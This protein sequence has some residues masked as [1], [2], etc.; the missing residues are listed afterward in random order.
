M[1]I[2]DTITNEY[3]KDKV[4]YE[5][6]DADRINALLKTKDFL[7]QNEWWEDNEFTGIYG[8]KVSSEEQHLRQI[9]DNAIYNP[10]EKCYY[11]EVKYFSKSKYG[12]IFPIQ[13]R[14]IFM[15]RREI[16]HYC[17]ENI[18]AIDIDLRA[19]PPIVTGKLR[20]YLDLLKY[21]TST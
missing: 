5:R 8:K 19:C 21:L 7:K 11:V 12:R 6:I 17:L 2:D 4:F 3:F 10:E 14:S 13:A 1:E 16:R 18:G 9:L 15:C 20:P